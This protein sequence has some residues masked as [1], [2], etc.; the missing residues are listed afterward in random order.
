MKS[1]VLYYFCIPLV[2]SLNIMS[3]FE[4]KVHRNEFLFQPPS[5]KSCSNSPRGRSSTK[6]AMIILN[7]ESTISSKALIQKTWNQC[8]IRIC[9]DGGANRLYDIF[10]TN[11][12][13]LPDQIKGDLDSI[14]PSVSDFYKSHGVQ[15]LLDE[16]QDSNDLDKC[17]QSVV[18]LCSPV[19]CLTATI[20]IIG[21]YGGRFDQEMAA[22]HALFKWDSYFYRI[23]LLGVPSIS[24]LLSPGLHRIEPS[25]IEKQPGNHCGLIPL[26]GPC[27]R[28]TSTGLG[29][30]LN[31]N[32]IAFGKL[33]STSNFIKPDVDVVEID[34]SDFVL[35]TSSFDWF[36][37]N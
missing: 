12:E 16:D 25:E 4:P 32:E 8:D 31:N 17:M 19:G 29:W 33:I 22:V 20:L 18:E 9:A 34:T 7:S 11:V 6:Y 13:F 14:K 15:V 1:L 35:W 21:A 23:V 28:I 27:R 37:P 5:D 36:L 2:S 30:D 10:G 24:F 3:T 26:N